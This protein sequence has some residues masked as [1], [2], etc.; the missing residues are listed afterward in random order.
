[1]ADA[2]RPGQGSP[3]PPTGPRLLPHDVTLPLAFRSAFALA[4]ISPGPDFALMMRIGLGAGH[5]AACR[6][7]LAITVGE[8]V[9]GEAALFGV[10]ALAVRCPLLDDAIRW[11]GGTFQLCL[12]AGALALTFSGRTAAQ[13]HAR[14]R[15]GIETMLGTVL[16]GLGIGLPAAG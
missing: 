5:A 11:A 1:M 14:A 4:L 8:I 9:C 12:A 3:P 2:G 7:S 13:L 10:A 15:R 6:T 16:A